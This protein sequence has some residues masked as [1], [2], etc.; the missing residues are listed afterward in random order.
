ML[1]ALLNTTDHKRGA[2]AKQIACCCVHTRTNK[3]GCCPALAHPGHRTTIA[4][5]TLEYS[6]Q[7]HGPQ[8]CQH[9]CCWTACSLQGLWQL[10]CW[11][12]PHSAATDC[13]VSAG[14]RWRKLGSSPLKRNLDQPCLHPSCTQGKHAQGTKHTRGFNEASSPTHKLAHS[15]KRATCTC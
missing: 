7:V 6:T 11:A 14:A 10:S 2:D 9:C 13:C 1:R 8:P 12:A 4:G 15:C 3:T 5:N